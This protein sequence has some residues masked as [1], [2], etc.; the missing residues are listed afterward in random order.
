MSTQ[1]VKFVV[2][3]PYFPQHRIICDVSGAH[4]GH[5]KYLFFSSQLRLP[6]HSH[7]AER[8][9]P[10]DCGSVDNIDDEYYLRRV[11]MT[12]NTTLEPFHISLQHA[13]SSQIRVLFLPTPHPTAPSTH[14]TRTV[15]IKCIICYREHRSPEVLPQCFPLPPPY[16]YDNIVLYSVFYTNSRSRSTVANCLVPLGR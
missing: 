14:T 3:K 6:L 13:S 7:T 10:N 9:A 4:L 8:R 1:Q 12:T 2:A 5:P 11:P 16:S 15:R